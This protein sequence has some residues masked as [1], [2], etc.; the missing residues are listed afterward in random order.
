MVSGMFETNIPPLQNAFG[1]NS[2]TTAFA[3]HDPTTTLPSADGVH[4]VNQ[5]PGNNSIWFCPYAIGGDDT[6]YLIKIVQ[7]RVHREAMWIPAGEVVIE[8]TS[9]AANGVAGA[10]ILDTEFFADLLTYQ[11]GDE[12]VKLPSV[13]ADQIAWGSWDLEGAGLIQFLVDINSGPVPTATTSVNLL[14]GTY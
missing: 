5:S 6:D 1:T 12:S 3:T 2:V 11:S 13:A 14:W 8:C 9:C 10:P 4:K 7:W